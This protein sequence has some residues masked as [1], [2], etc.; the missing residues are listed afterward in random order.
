MSRTPNAKENPA[1]AAIEPDAHFLAD[2]YA[3]LPSEDAQMYG[4][5]ILRARALYHLAVASIRYPGQSAVGILATNVT[6]AS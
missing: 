3:H 6:R 5:E 1:P 4:P 2:Y